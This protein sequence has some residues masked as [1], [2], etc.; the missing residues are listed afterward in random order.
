MGYRVYRHYG[1]ERR[2]VLYR[3][4]AENLF[5]EIPN[6]SIDLVVTSPPY[7]MQKDYE[8]GMEIDEFIRT[9]SEVLPEV[10]RITKPGGSIC[11]QVGYYFRNHVATPLDY[12]VYEAMKEIE[13]ITLRDRIIWT[14]G[15]G[16]HSTR[17]FSGRHEVVLWFT[18]G[19]NYLFDLDKVRIPQKYPGKRSYKGKN[20]GEYSGN[21]LGKNPTNVWDIPNVKAKHVEKT[22]HPCQFPVGLAER[23]ILALSPHDGIV[24]DPF[25]GSGTTG[26]A[27]LIHSRRFVGAELNHK[28]HAVASDRLR[29][30]MLGT[31]RYRP[32]EKSIYEPAPD[33]PLRKNPFLKYKEKL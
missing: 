32:V 1:D 18:K 22:C 12:L 5:R 11:W 19:D 6:E 14:F 3:G 26:V 13:G 21:P 7:C 16:L 10:S 30:A 24:L 20:K 9:H 8:K 33:S 23:L 31:I 17:K 2:C 29:Q 25:A 15:H 27:A 4:E 28:Y